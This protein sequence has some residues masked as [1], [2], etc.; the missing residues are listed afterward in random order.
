MPH[1]EGRRR[2]RGIALVLA[3]LATLAI[4]A[5]VASAQSGQD[6]D[7][8]G[9]GL[10]IYSAQCAT[11]HGA[12]GRG[13]QGV[14]PSIQDASPA[15]IDFVIRTGRMPLPNEDAPV[16]RRKPVLND[17]QRR[18]VVAYVRTFADQE[19]EIPSPDPNAGELE[20][21]RELYESNCIA[22][23]SAF[24]RGIAVSQSDVAPGLFAASPIE[25][26]EA[27]RVGPGV[28]PVFGEDSLT[29]DDVDSLIRYIG[30]LEERPTPGGFAIGRSGPVTDGF[31]AW[32]L[33]GLGLVAAAY[34]I[35]EHRGSE[36][37]ATYEPRDS[38]LDDQGGAGQEPRDE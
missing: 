8:V 24:G 37:E 9:R 38:E 20:H 23:H 28:M 32:L 26:A 27:I 13:I 6:S 34:F 5:T 2:S 3:V 19:P 1:D 18:A 15:L 7:L 35:G 21:G 16:I 31:V 33:G 10:D 36:P 17:D 4:G 30:F 11:C 14:A 29:D 12:E 25:I 22:C